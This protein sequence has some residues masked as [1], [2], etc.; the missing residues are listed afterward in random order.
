MKA[1]DVLVMP[2]GTGHQRLSMSR[3]LLVVGGYPKQGGYDMCKPGKT[4]HD[5]AATRVAKVPAPK[6]DPVYGADG[7]LPQLWNR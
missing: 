7:P 2:A 6:A 4:D 1:G 3:D 5:P